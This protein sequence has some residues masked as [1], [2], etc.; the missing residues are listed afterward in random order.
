M[1]YVKYT[2]IGVSGAYDNIQALGHF[3]VSRGSKIHKTRNIAFGITQMHFFGVLYL[4][5]SESI[6]KHVQNI[7]F[8]K[9]FWFLGQNLAKNRHFTGQ[10]YTKC[11]TLL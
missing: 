9:I 8:S 1:K 4:Y 6:K 2:Y 10:I 3:L 5:L 7:T 11:E